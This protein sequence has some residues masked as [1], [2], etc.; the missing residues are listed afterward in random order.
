VAA[1]A[2]VTAGL[3]AP[4]DGEH[5]PSSRARGDGAAVCAGAVPLGEEEVRRVRGLGY[6]V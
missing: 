6:T 4:A 3:E 1:E 5:V 2:E